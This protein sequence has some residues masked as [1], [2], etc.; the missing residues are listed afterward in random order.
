MADVVYYLSYW[1]CYG[2]DWCL[3][4]TGLDIPNIGRWHALRGADMGFYRCIARIPEDGL[5]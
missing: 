3:K 2:R 4:K 1:G 5:K